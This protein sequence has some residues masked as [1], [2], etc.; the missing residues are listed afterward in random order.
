[1]ATSNDFVGT[2]PI[3]LQEVYNQPFAL[4]KWKKLV[5]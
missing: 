3:F 4:W 5:G 2:F 1:M